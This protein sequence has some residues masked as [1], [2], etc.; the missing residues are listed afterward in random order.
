MFV[1]CGKCAQLAGQIDMAKWQEFVNASKTDRYGNVSY[2]YAQSYSE[3]YATIAL[4]FVF[5]VL[6]LADVAAWILNTVWKIKLMK[7]EKE[8]LAGNFVREVA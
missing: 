7:G 3:S 1:I 8:L 4:G 2:Y 6:I 5:A